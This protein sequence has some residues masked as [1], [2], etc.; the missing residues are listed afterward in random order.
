MKHAFRELG[1]KGTYSKC[2]AGL[3]FKNGI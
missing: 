2:A 1:A 3:L